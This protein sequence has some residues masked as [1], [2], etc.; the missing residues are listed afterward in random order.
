ME[1]HVDPTNALSDAGQQLAPTAYDAMVRRLIFRKARPTAGMRDRLEELRDLIDQLDESIAQKLGARMDI[2]ARIG[3]HKRQHRVA[4][5]QPERWER[6]MKQQLNLA[7]GL[8][9]SDTFVQEFMDAVHRE[10]IRRQTV[11]DLVDS[12][13]VGTGSQA[14]G[15]DGQ[16]DAG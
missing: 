14:T 16:A 1:V 3:D 8:G 11:E 9:L 4:I 2:A 10:S 15:R 12:G 7:K 5:L 6:I 13:R